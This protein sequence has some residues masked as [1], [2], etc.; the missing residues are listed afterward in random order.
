MSE[1][2]IYSTT[3]FHWTQ[4]KIPAEFYHFDFGVFA[5]NLTVSNTADLYDFDFD[6]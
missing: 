2:R 5:D 4:L 3:N 1:C 6:E